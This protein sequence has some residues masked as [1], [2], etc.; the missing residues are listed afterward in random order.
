MKRTLFL[1]LGIILAAA[2]SFSCEEPQ[3]EVKPLATPSVTATLNVAKVTLTWRA[4]VDATS[5]QVEYKEHSAD[6]FSVHGKTSNSPYEVNGLDFG[7]SYDFR[8]KA[9]CGDRESE[10]SNIVT[11]EL[12]RTL[13]KPAIKANAGISFAEVSWEAVEGAASYKVQHKLATD[14]EYVTDYDGDGED[15]GFKFRVTGLQPAIS[16]DL[17]VAAN[18]EGFKETYSDVTTVTTTASPSTLINTAAQFKAWLSSVNAQTTD[19]AA[20]GCDIDMTGV[21]ITSATGFAGTL[22]GQGFAIRNLVSSVPLFETLTGTIKDVVLDGTCTFNA[23][24]LIFGAIAAQDMKATYSGIVSSATVVYTPTADNLDG[25][26]AIG[27]LVGYPHGSTFTSCVITEA[28]SVTMN[29]AGFRIGAGGIGGIAGYG[30]NDVYMDACINRGA[31]TLNAKC[32]APHQEPDANDLISLKYADVSV[33]GIIGRN[34]CADV[35]NVLKDC[36]NYG[37]VTLNETAIDEIPNT[38][39]N[40]YLKTTCVGGIM[41]SA[42]KYNEGG[43]SVDRAEDNTYRCRNYGEIDVDFRTSTG[44]T[45]DGYRTILRVGGISGQYGSFSNCLNEGNIDVKSDASG[46]DGYGNNFSSVGGICGAGT[47]NKDSHAYY[48]N[49]KANITVDGNCA[50]QVGGIFGHRGKQIGNKVKEG[51]NITAVFI[52]NGSKTANQGSLGGLVGYLKGGASTFPIKACSCEANLNCYVRGQKFTDQHNGPSVGGL[53]G[54]TADFEASGTGIL[55]SRDGNPCSFTGTVSSSEPG[56]TEWSI[57]Q[58]IGTVIGY[59]K[60]S[61]K[62][63]IYGEKDYP[64]KVKANI[65]MG[66]DLNPNDCNRA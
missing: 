62:T 50:A 59:V 49:V 27:G 53:I 64:I 43:S 12:S 26:Y 40:N 61:N 38:G 46:T 56:S 33:G 57:G 2:A 9:L 55:A 20:L 25:D 52:D 1:I 4:V 18:A 37:K 11:V 39:S 24:S 15:C 3:P 35:A 65:M 28:A 21:T 42:L 19:V 41:G 29:A 45:I 10:Y 16:Y 66:Q 23:G 44:S 34:G 6:E 14:T 54:K 7:Y 51:T 32:A 48:C 60:N 30:A 63:Q 8:I 36:E 58:N 31:V 13:P 47:Y 5:Y 17:R 22:E